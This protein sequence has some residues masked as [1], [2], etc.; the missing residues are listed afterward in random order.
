MAKKMDKV[1]EII[2]NKLRIPIYDREGGKKALEGIFLL[3]DS[4]VVDTGKIQK[5]VPRSRK[6]EKVH[7]MKEVA[8]L[9]DQG[10]KKAEIIRRVGAS[11]VTISKDILDLKAQ[12]KA[13]K[14]PEKKTAEK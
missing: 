14:K 12:K 3:Y 4:K 9:L 7:R 10:L 1:C 13:E 2:F 11:P 6:E 8:K 5:A